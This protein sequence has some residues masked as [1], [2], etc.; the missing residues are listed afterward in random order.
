MNGLPDRTTRAAGAHS[1]G[2]FAW[3]SRLAAVVLA[4]WLIAAAVFVSAGGLRRVP[5]PVPV[6]TLSFATLLVVWFVRPLRTWASTFA[7]RG[8]VAI[9]LVRFVGL[10]FLW[11]SAQGRLSPAFAV[12]A[13]VGDVIAA[14]GAMVL[15]AWGDSKSRGWRRALLAWNVFGL[16]DMAM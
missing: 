3:V 11:L 16:A 5:P 4:T 9:H 14:L 7:Y 13:G 2:D 1:S 15:L 6:G 12:P 10:Y 8:L